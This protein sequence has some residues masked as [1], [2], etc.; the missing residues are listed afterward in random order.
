[1]QAFIHSYLPFSNF[2]SYVMHFYKSILAYL[3]KTYFKLFEI[4]CSTFAYWQALQKTCSKVKT[5]LIEAKFS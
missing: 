1:M 4:F 3:I 5:K 2:L